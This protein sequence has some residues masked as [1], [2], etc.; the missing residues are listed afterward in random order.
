MTDLTALDTVQDLRNQLKSMEADCAAMRIA[1]AG[2]T[3]SKEPEVAV[4]AL[5]DTLS[6]ARIVQQLADYERAAKT[7]EL[8]AIE[9]LAKEALA[10]AEKAPPGPWHIG[11]VNDDF[12]I[13]ESSN[14]DEV[15]SIY[16]RTAENFVCSMRVD[17]PALANAVLELCERLFITEAVANKN[18]AERDIWKNRAILTEHNYVKGDSTV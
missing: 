9:A 18:A 4:T 14:G 8:T 12:V 15:G 13:F 1:L 11:S 6:G 16:I 10:R 2:Y 7:T 17:V 3:G 5:Y